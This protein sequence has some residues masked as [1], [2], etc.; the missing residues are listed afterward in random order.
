MEILLNGTQMEIP[1]RLAPFVANW[2]TAHYFK[3]DFGFLLSQ[4]FMHR[5]YRIHI[6]RFIAERQACLPLH[7]R[8]GEAILQLAIQGPLRCSVSGS[9]E[10]LLKPGH[11]NFFY[12]PPGTH[13][14]RMEAGES[15]C[16]C[17][18]LDAS[19]LEELAE[20]R[21]E[22]KDLLSH[23]HEASKQGICLTTQPMDYRIQELI[24][25]M[26][27]C[28]E[29]GGNLLVE[30]STNIRNLLNLY[31]KSLNDAEYCRDLRV[32]GYMSA[33]TS[34]R[35]EITQNPSIQHHTLAYFSK[36]YNMS[37]STLKR[38]FKAVFNK[39]LHGFVRE[40]CMKK[41]SWMRNNPTLSLDDIADEVGYADKSGFLKSF[42]QFHNR[43]PK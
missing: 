10:I 31:R 16:I 20:S 9:G 26:R 21:Q 33:M 28:K 14:L 19:L 22:M 2:A 43:M 35:E 3:C 37:Q 25:G 29:T 15:E 38:Y 18:M 24:K 13:K 40:E 7:C 30:F 4:V 41:A 42:K 39:T 1:I 34:I 6:Y 11:Y 23:L 12:L 17:I 27:N 32:T 5:F 8:H 36:K